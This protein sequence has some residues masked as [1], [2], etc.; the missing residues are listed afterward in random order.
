[1]TPTRHWN[2]QHFQSEIIQEEQQL[3]LHPK[4]SRTH[5]P[6]TRPHS[7]TCIYAEIHDNH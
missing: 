2:Q 4:S 7:R 5:Q 6:H 1:M 3:C